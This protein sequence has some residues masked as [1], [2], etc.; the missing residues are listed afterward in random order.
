MKVARL[1][2]RLFGLANRRSRLDW[3]A[4]YY[5]DLPMAAWDKPETEYRYRSYQSRLSLCI[6]AISRRNN[7]MSQNNLT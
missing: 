6:H 7:T 4:H 2:K 5:R 1:S 3:L